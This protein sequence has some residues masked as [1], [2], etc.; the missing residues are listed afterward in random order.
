[1]GLVPVQQ[2]FIVK[3]SGHEVAKKKNKFEIQAFFYDPFELSRQK[4]DPLSPA[5]KTNLNHVPFTVT[6]DWSLV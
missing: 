5:L 3:T 6:S 1:M 2:Y 4:C